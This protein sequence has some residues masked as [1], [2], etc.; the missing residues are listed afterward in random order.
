VAVLSGLEIDG[1][2][3]V[4]LLDND[5][6]SHVEV[7]ADDLDELV[8]GLL[9][10]AVCLY[11][12]GKGLGHTNGV[13][14]LHEGA[15]GKSSFEEGLGDPAGEVGCR[16][17]DL[18]VI[19]SREGSSAVGAPAAVRVDDDLAAS[20]TGVTL[21]ATDD[22]K[23]GR[24]DLYNVSLCQFVAI[25]EHNAHGRQSCRPSTSLE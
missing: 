12:H 20:E 13:G 5:T 4:E 8:R 16:A 14:E 1:L 22:E 17:I 23:T 6:W 24:L 7:G 11:E 10:C 9:G 2:G 25:I 21:W 19:L 3:K 18:R 15:A